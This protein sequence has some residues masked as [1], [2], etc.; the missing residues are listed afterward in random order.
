MPVNILIARVPQSDHVSTQQIEIENETIMPDSTQLPNEAQ[1]V[2]V[3]PTASE[4]ES[5]DSTPTDMDQHEAKSSCSSLTNSEDAS[6]SSWSMDSSNKVSDHESEIILGCKRKRRDT[7]SVSPKSSSFGSP[8]AKHPRLTFAKDSTSAVSSLSDSSEQISSPACSS[9]SNKENLNISEMDTELNSEIP[10][11]S[12]PVSGEKPRSSHPQRKRNSTFVLSTEN[13]TD[14][15][16]PVAGKE[17][18]SNVDEP[19]E[20]QTKRLRRETFSVSPKVSSVE[21][22]EKVVTGSNSTAV[23]V[24]GDD[25]KKAIL[26]ML[27]KRV[28]ER[29][30]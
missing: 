23:G 19:S 4:N 26:D 24:D 18:A 13:P 3:Q 8:I 6:C 9:A 5:S 16:S 7:Y 2:N 28:E 10:H 27:D 11:F 30:E 14:A 17:A 1:P 20:P 29:R 15:S 21:S 25:M 22:D 12:P